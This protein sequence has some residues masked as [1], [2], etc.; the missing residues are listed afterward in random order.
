MPFCTNNGNKLQKQNYIKFVLNL[1]IYRPPSPPPTDLEKFLPTP[2]I[3]FIV[4]FGVC[5]EDADREDNH[6]DGMEGKQKH[7]QLFQVE[8]KVEIGKSG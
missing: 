2:L 5:G 7:K 8:L 6:G 3:T 1:K 4:D